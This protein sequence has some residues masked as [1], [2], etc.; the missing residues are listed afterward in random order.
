MCLWEGGGRDVQGMFIGCFSTCTLLHTTIT[1]KIA[2][3]YHSL[4]K[5]KINSEIEEYE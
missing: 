2:G 1:D 5:K 3:E 4:T